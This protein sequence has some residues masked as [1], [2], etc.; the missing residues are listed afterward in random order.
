MN[1]RKSKDFGFTKINPLYSS[2]AEKLPSRAFN[3][4]KSNLKTQPH[5]SEICI[6]YVNPLFIKPLQLSTAEHKKDVIFF[7]FFFFFFFFWEGG[8]EVK[9][10]YNSSEPRVY[11]GI[12]FTRVTVNLD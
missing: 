12:P 5:I 8:G 6:I 9:D 2:F 4:Y 7:F 10:N 3:Y 1:P 11:L